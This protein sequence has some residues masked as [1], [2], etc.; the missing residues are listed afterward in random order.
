MNPARTP[1][2]LFVCKPLG[3]WPASPTLL[4]WLERVLLLPSNTDQAGYAAMFQNDLYFLSFIVTAVLTVD[5][6]AIFVFL[7]A[8]A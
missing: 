1:G 8:N 7:Q 3:M 5:V 6:V 4:P 2:F